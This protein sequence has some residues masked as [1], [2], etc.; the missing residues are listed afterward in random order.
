MHPTNSEIITEQKDG[1]VTIRLNRP[2]VLNA[3]NRQMLDQL[4]TEVARLHQDPSVR[5]VA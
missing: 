2:S 4:D 5:I 3:I 1:I